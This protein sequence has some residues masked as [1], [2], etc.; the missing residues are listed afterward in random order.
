MRPPLKATWVF[1]RVVY[2]WEATESTGRRDSRPPFRKDWALTVS[3]MI[4]LWVLDPIDVATNSAR[5]SAELFYRVISPLYPSPTDKEGLGI[6][7][8]DNTRIAVIVINDETLKTREPKETWPPRFATHAEVVEKVLLYNPKALF[9]D[10][11]FFDERDREDVDILTTT[12]QRRLPPVE[13]H[14]A[15]VE[16]ISRSKECNESAQRV[17]V[18]LAGAPKEPEGKERSYELSVIPAL[19]NAVTGTVSTRYSTEHE[20]P[21]NSYVLFDCDQSE[22]SAALAMY[23]TD[24]MDWQGWNLDECPKDWMWRG[25]PN[26]LSIHWA[27]WGDAAN[28]RGSYSCDT[29]PETM[30]GRIAQFVKIWFRDLFHHDESWTEQFQS[31]PPHRSLSAHSFLADDSDTLAEFMEGR[32]VF[33]GGNFAMADDLITP[34]THRPVPGVFLHAMALDNLLRFRGNY[35]RL[36]G[37]SGIFAVTTWLTLAVIAFVGLCTVAAWNGYEALTKSPAYPMGHRSS[38]RPERHGSQAEKIWDWLRPVGNQIIGFS[39]VFVCLV[40]AGLGVCAALWVGFSVLR[41]APINYIGILAFM[42]IHTIARSFREIA[43][44]IL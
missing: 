29:L 4:V 40:I 18:F 26:K 7:L 34:P 1:L 12:L 11:G 36:E 15:C 30:P 32:Y 10:F 22:P 25:G 31:C 19:K 23:A 21:Y 37:D 33:Y 24:K 28:S 3:L 39:W 16:P 14:S 9:I 20:L 8:D 5:V 13:P 38:S 27:S 43:G 41:F 2:R 6:P 42:G 44:A 35:I 17:P